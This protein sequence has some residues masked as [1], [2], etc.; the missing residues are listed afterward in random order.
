MGM[1]TGS[2]TRTTWSSRSR[3]LTPPLPD[4]ERA[5]LRPHPLRGPG[6]RC[7]DLEAEVEGEVERPFEIVLRR[8]AADAVADLTALLECSGNGRVFLIP[9]SASAGNWGR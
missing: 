5:V 6:Y 4:P 9:R 3:P 7:E 1:I 2:G 8:V